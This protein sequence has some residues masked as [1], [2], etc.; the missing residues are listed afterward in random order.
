MFFNKNKIRKIRLI[1]DIENDFENK[2][3]AVFDFPFQ[4]NPNTQDI[5]MSVFLD[6]WPYLLTTK[7][8]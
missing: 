3:C 6:L 7:L 5:F 4:I 2:N 8:C 1:F